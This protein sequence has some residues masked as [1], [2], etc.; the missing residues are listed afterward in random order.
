[1]KNRARVRRLVREVEEYLGGEGVDPIVSEYF[2]KP[3]GGAP[4]AERVVEGRKRTA[5]EL[6]YLEGEIHG[7]FLAGDKPTAADF[8]LYPFLG[9]VGRVTVRKPETKLTELVPP[10]IAAWQKRIESLPFFDKTFPPHWR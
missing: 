9:Y 7:A 1:V 8:V 3:G 4:D 10:G 6:K 5:E 2:F